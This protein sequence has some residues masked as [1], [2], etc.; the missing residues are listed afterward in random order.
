MQKS[1]KGISSNYFN[2]ILIAFSFVFLVVYLYRVDGIKDIALV[3]AKAHPGWLLAALGC[4]AAYWLLDAYVLHL[5]IKPVHPSQRFG[6][7]MRLTLIGQYFN[8][9]T[10][11]ASGGQPAQ[12]Y[13]L[14]KRG[15]PLGETMTALLT[16]FIVYQI[17]LTVYCLATLILRFTFF[18][19]EV[20]VLMLAV[21]VGFVVHTAV[22]V[23]LISVAFFKTGTIKAA[24]FI[25][26]LLARI[27]IVKDPVA[28]KE[29]VDKELESFHTQFQ[30]MS[31]HKMHLLK[32]SL[33]TIVELTVYFLIGNVIYLSFRLSGA[34][35]VTLVASQA[36]VLMI[37]AFMPIPGALGAAE[38]SFYI[39]F[40]LFFPKNMISLAVVLWR[41]ITFYLPIVVG[42][43]VT[44]FEKKRAGNLPLEATPVVDELTETGG[45]PIFR[46]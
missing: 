41:L 1:D 9:V 7:T 45:K 27:K 42:L 26:N 3:I 23:L 5:A 38:S 44:L 8:S 13:F 43:I 19:K 21:I 32:M 20:K 35:S 18:M 14:V 29:F 11:F 2:L 24:N 30:Y 10:P 37:A 12:A 25:I 28:K 40:S 34:D 33:L 17:T 39:F 4:I 22:T 6:V 31:K 15:A 36:F 46:K 16:K